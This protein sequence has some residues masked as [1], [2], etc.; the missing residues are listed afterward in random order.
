M[1]RFPQLIVILCLILASPLAIA[2][3]PSRPNIVFFLVDDMGFADAGFNGSTEFRTPNIDALAARGAIL[4]DFYVQPSCSPTRA[5]FVTGRYP[6]HTGVYTIFNPTDRNGL[7]LEERTIADAIQAAD[8]TTAIC[9]KWHLGKLDPANTPTKRGFTHQYGHLGGGLSYETHMKV[10]ELDWYRNDELSHDEGYTTHLIAKEASALI[11]DQPSDKPLFLYVPFNAVHA[12]YGVPDS[13]TAPYADLSKTRRKMAGLI[14][15]VDEA[16]GQVIGALEEKGILENTLIL[17]CSDNGGVA[18]GRYADNLPLRA[19]K[20]TIYE[21]GVRVCAFAT[22]PGV[23]PEGIHV[24]EPIHIVDLY[25]TLVTL[26]GGNLNQKL[27]VDGLDIWPV[28][29]Q[30]A[31]SPHDAILL[32]GNSTDQLAVRMGDWK[33]LVNPSDNDAEEGDDEDSSG[34]KVEL[35]NL[36]DDVS[37]QHDLSSQFP[38][39]VKQM[40][41]RL[42]EFTK[43]A[44]TGELIHSKRRAK[45]TAADAN[46]AR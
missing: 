36:A 35:Y 4:D 18:P 8:Y 38:E 22:W 43:E 9:G 40:Q 41:A 15:T 13:Y 1:K 30:R 31:K 28:L 14:A 6:T 25:P 44:V 16:V 11:T 10:G 5:A 45:R 12:P 42:E 20:G 33:L 27:P 19:G 34:E 32:A 17:F 29:T 21:G 2:A 26:A 24:S 3:P 46:K 23:I 37:E 7:P 39:R